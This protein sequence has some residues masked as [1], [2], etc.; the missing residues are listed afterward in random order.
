LLPRIS[1]PETTSGRKGYIYLDTINTQGGRTEIAGIIRAFTEEEL[2]QLTNQLQQAFRTTKALYPRA[3]AELKITDEYKNMK[4]AL[5]E[6]VV[7]LAKQA[8]KAEDIEPVT[9]A[10]RGGTDGAVLSLGGLPTPD[11]FAGQFNIHSE[12]EYAD[13]DVMEASLRTVLR[14]ISL[15]DLQPAPQK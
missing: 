1:R 2:E 8:M 15:W 6:H 11:I 10:A 9:R 4:T 12:R 7:T 14:L 3:T 5:P 13:A